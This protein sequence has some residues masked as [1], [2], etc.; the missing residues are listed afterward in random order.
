MNVK[1]SVKTRLPVATGVKLIAAWPTP[2]FAIFRLRKPGLAGTKGRLNATKRMM[3]SVQIPVM[4]S[5]VVNTVAVVLVDHA[6]RASCTSHASMI[7]Y[8]YWYV[9]MNV[10]INV[11]S[12]HLAKR[13]VRTAVSTVSVTSGVGSYVFLVWNHAPGDASIISV[14]NCAVNHATGQDVIS[15]AENVC[16]ATISVLDCVGNRVQQ[17]AKY[18]TDRK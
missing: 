12:A 10:M 1:K 17:T 14:R 5:W 7:A 9:V 6:S 2:S 3:H 15:L 4:L 16:L 8:E 11:T 18:V 13:S